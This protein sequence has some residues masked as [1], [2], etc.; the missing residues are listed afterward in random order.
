MLQRSPTYVTTLPTVDPV[1]RALRRVL[2]ERAAFS[3]VR[4]KNVLQQMAVYQLSRRRPGTLRGMLRKVLE[5]QLPAGYDIDRH[6]SPR[7]DPWDQ[8]LCLVPDGDLF[9]AIG[10]GRASVVTDVIDT[11]TETGIRLA[12][13]E[14]LEADVV[15]TATGLELLMLGGIR[16]VVDG[17]DVAYPSR[18]TYKGMMLEGVPN[19]AFALG[20]T[21][22]SWTLK[23]DLTGEYV[24]RLLRHMDERGRTCCV[25]VNDDP[26]VQ[27]APLLD[28]SAGYVLRSLH[29]LP[30]AGS[31]A[32][33]R[34]RMNYAVDLVALRLG[35]VDDGVMRFSSPDR[36]PRRRAAEPAP[37]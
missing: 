37:A 26:T 2:P 3:A 19:L 32:P 10:S 25:P 4:W 22:A 29:E 20:Y 12:S 36:A 27:E 11:F 35:R 7:Y 15:V 14:E 28:F 16:L 13:G 31:K 9:R 34:L 1:A 24:S 6:F 21:N 30:K 23:A 33:W 18:M 8:R 17:E 5:Q